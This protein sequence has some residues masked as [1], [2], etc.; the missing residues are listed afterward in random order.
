MPAFGHSARVVNEHGLHELTEVTFAVSPADLRRIGQFLIETAEGVETGNWF[1]GHSHLR[2]FDRPWRA[3][4]PEFDVIAIHP[5][6]PRRA[7]NETKQA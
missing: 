3:D 4:H 1:N 6:D 5:S 2:D 7:M